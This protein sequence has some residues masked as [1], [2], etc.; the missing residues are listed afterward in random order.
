VL[1]KLLV[2]FT[3][4]YI[5]KPYRSRNNRKLRIAILVLLTTL[6][7]LEESIGIHLDSL[8]EA[9]ALEVL[10]DIH[11]EEHQIG[12]GLGQEHHLYRIGNNDITVDS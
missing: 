2:V 12:I 4:D 3:R 10:K 8:M 9:E 6:E 7:G 11:R 1:Q 5:S